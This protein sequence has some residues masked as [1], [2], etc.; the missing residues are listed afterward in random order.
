M[1]EDAVFFRQAAEAIVATSL[2]AENVDPTI[3]ELLSRIKYVSPEIK[4]T[5]VNTS[6]SLLPTEDIKIGSSEKEPD[7]VFKPKE[8]QDVEDSGNEDTQ[9]AKGT[10]LQDRQFHCAKCKLVFRR[11]SD[12]RRHERTHLPVLPNICSQCGKGFARKD[13]LK[14]HFDTL[15]CRRN[16][17]KLLS[18]GGDINEILERAQ[19]TGTGL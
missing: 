5:D 10:L 1:S 14:R 16:R 17:S 9:D 3:R 12:L 15:T 18:I 13:A 6:T 19:Q 2:N 7:V 11:S 4:K 8:R